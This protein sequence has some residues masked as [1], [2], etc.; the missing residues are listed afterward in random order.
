MSILIAQRVVKAFTLSPIQKFNIR[1][2]L[3]PLKYEKTSKCP[4]NTM[5]MQKKQRYKMNVKY[6]KS[7]SK[8]YKGWVSE[9]PGE[10]KICET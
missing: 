8:N 10:V 2:N 4:K 9:K 5:K 7:I 6:V 3:D 1:V